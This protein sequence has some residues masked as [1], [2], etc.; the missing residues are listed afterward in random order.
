MQIEQEDIF[1]N[2]DIHEFIF[3]T[4]TLKHNLLKII[5]GMFIKKPILIEGSPGIGKTTIVQNLF[6]KLNKKIHRVNLSEHTDMIDLI[7][8]QF[9]SNDSN[10]KFKWI[11][12]ILLTAMKNGDWIIIDEMN[13]ANQS[14]LE[15][16]N[17]ILDEKQSL[18]IPELNE[19][20]KAHPEFQIFATQNPVNQGGGRKFLPKNFLNRFIKIYLDELN[21]KDY[22]E[23]LEKIFIK[24]NSSNLIDKNIIKNLVEFNEEVKKEIIR[25]KISLSE[26]GE[27]NL[28]TIIKLFNTYKL[29][30]YDL[31]VICNTFYLSHIRQ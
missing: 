7:G 4:E 6:K 25:N 3:D 31:I 18:F 1:N 10:I 26:V 29:N 23:I 11:D 5:R 2:N 19:E 21:I 22:T 16:L 24:D 20:I 17:S 12:G 13:L 15:G 14:I 28:R 27:F 9:P 8:S 30:K